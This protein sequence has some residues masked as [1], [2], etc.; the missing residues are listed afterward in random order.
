MTL[1]KCGCGGEVKEGNRYIN[2]HHIRGKHFS[3]EHRKKISEAKKGENNPQWKDEY[4]GY[5]ALHVWVKRHKSK[6]KKC[7]ICKKVKFLELCN[8]SNEIN[9]VERYETGDPVILA[10]YNRNLKN[11]YYACVKCH[12]I[13]DGRIDNLIRH[14][15]DKTFLGKKHSEESKMKMSVSLKRK[16]QAV[17][18][19]GLA[20]K[21][22][23]N[24]K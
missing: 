16:W 18:K 19:Q 14:R 22:S 5:D 6:P 8:I 1:C 24:A 4:V 15:G 12:K 13:S 10:T 9:V 21:K 2:N 17:K 20:W 7:I 11:W 3:S 23:K